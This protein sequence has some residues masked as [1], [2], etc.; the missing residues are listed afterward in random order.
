MTLRFRT[1]L[2]L[3]SYIHKKTKLFCN[4]PFGKYADGMTNKVIYDLEAWIRE[5]MMKPRRVV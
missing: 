5:P 1:K 4:F 3:F 2:L